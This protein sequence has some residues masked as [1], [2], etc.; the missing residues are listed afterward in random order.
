[1]NN[2]VDINKKKTPT[3]TYKVHL[4]TGMA[5]TITTSLH[6]II[7]TDGDPANESFVTFFTDTDKDKPI[8]IFNTHIV[9]TIINISLDDTVIYETKKD[10]SV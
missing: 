3:F 8:A 6:P 1:M 10:K 7:M 5:Y 4:N 2:V 9:D